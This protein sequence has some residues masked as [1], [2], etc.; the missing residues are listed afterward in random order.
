VSKP[1]TDERYFN[2]KCRIVWQNNRDSNCLKLPQDQV[3]V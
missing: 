2:I 1:V 3:I